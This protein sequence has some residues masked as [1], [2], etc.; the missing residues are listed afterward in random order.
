MDDDLIKFKK[1]LEYF[2]AHLSYAQSDSEDSIGYKSYIKPFVDNN[3]FFKTGQ[4]Y[5]G[6]NIQNQIKEW[7]NIQS[8]QLY[9]NVQPNFG[10]YTAKKSYLNWSDTGIDVFCD[11][12]NNEVKALSIGYAF[13][14]KK[15]TEYEVRLTKTVEELHLF[16]N[17]LDNAL[18]EFMQAFVK[19][20]NDYD[21]HKGDYYQQEQ[22]YYQQEKNNK[23]MERNKIYV[24]L[25]NN[26]HNLI[27]TGAPG[28]G[29][30]YL[31]R[32][33]AQQMIFGEVKENTTDEE[34]KQFNEQC[35]FVQ[36]H[37]S[38]DYTDFVE[39][40]RPINDENG[41]IGFERKDG[42]F[43][44]FCARALR[45][46]KGGIQVSN[47]DAAYDLLVDEIVQNNNTIEFETAIQKKKFVIRVN[48]K[49]N[50][51][52]IPQTEVQTE[53]TITKEMLRAYIE[54][55]YIKYWKPYLVVIGDYM[56]SKYCEILSS[57]KPD[58]N[59]K[60]VFIIDEI[61]R[62][63]M[64]KIFGELFFSIDP[65]YR[66]EKGRVMTQYNNLIEE[67]DVFKNG[68]YVPENVYI[69]GT[70]NDID[71]SVE[72]MDFA[73]RRRFAFKEIEAKDRVVMLD[74]IPKYAEDAKKRMN[75]LNSAIENIDG[76]S[77]AYH[78]G[79]AY[80]LKLKNYLN[81]NK[82]WDSLWN[83]HLEGLLRE[84]LRGMPEAVENLKSLAKAY[85]YES[86]SNNGQ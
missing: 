61:N 73:F 4:G 18:N 28:T 37:P 53:M 23:I 63:E 48:N 51:G 38:Y 3:K 39:G 29:K 7:Q 19:E 42:V 52:A 49:R 31:A 70:M 71:R 81:D 47:F 34:K 32:Q 41:N 65:G 55:G 11:W 20:I 86:D 27:L 50:I 15:P 64:S 54:S 67:G 58:P 43:K 26:N 75:D 77:K 5:N 62:G 80:F 46:Q 1:V 74:E 22:N 56:K 79:P 44:E 85:G 57:E 6:N 35:G 33:I 14:W 66:G 24:N 84:Y 25:L 83:N 13:W 45:R 78:I 9:I 30:T 12:E 68:F 17:G 40:L 10:E 16:E 2:I 59:A 76:L 69:I 82:R 36:F 72:S 60:F 8:H 21:N